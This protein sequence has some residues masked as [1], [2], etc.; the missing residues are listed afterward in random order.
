MW[1]VSDVRHGKAL[2]HCASHGRPLSL[3]SR[4]PQTT[5]AT[6][7]QPGNIPLS[8]PRSRSTL[9]LVLYAREPRRCATG[10]SVS[11]ASQMRPACVW[12]TEGAYYAPCLHHFT[13]RR[14]HVV[15]GCWPWA[16]A[17]GLR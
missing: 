3:L 17:R 6:G 13:N 8:L 1:V 12:L 5:P 4:P 14:I 15:L 16:A 10:R 9:R 2:Q 11:W 7:G